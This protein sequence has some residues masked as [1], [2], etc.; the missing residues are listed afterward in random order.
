MEYVIRNYEDRDYDMLKN[1]WHSQNEPAPTKDLIPIDSTFILEV[2]K[3]PIVSLSV[4]LTNTSGMC[5]LEN[6]IADPL[7]KGSMR[8]E[9]S[10][11]ITNY[12]LTFA[13]GMGYKR[14][15]CF[16]YK[17]KLK[18]RYK[19]LGMKPTINNLTSFVREL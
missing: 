16:S 1:W 5:I 8:K 15:V 13:M 7:K 17:D 12:A 10:S 14:A 6:F 19:D 9:C 4:I 11:V 2:D 18:Q 3:E